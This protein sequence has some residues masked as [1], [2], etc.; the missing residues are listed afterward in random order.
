MGRGGSRANI[1][2]VDNPFAGDLPMNRRTFLKATGAVGA[3]IGLTGL[4]G[5]RL[6]ADPI[7]RTDLVLGAPNAEKLGWHLGCQAYTFH[8]STLFEA[9]DKTASLG[10]HYIEVFPGQK[11]S[12]EQP[13]CEV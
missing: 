10:L 4:G 12:P 8:K 9:I 11:L 6:L 1:T 3:G 5:S 2:T 13:Q 7:R